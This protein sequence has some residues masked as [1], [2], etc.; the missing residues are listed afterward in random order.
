MYFLLAGVLG[1]ALKYFGI[2]P[3]STWSWWVMFFPFVAAASWWTWADMSGYTQKK[4]MEKMDEKKKYRIDRQRK[5]MGI[6]PRKR[7]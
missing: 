2:S 4:K 3:F 6:L 1:L 7:R 5:A